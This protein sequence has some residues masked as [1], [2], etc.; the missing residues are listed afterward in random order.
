MYYNSTPLIGINKNNNITIL[1]LNVCTNS[2]SKSSNSNHLQRKKEKERTLL[3]ASTSHSVR[4]L[5]VHFSSHILLP[6]YKS[7]CFIL[8]G[9]KVLKDEE[10][11]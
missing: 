11:Q 8:Y 6:R 2:V 7:T 4:T 1:S 3:E 9:N 5:T 10:K